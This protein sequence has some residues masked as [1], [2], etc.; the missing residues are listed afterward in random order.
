MKP[1]RTE[2]FDQRLSFESVELKDIELIIDKA[3][4][5]L[6]EKQNRLTRLD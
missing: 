2:T 5:N 1:E 6:P 3:V 4:R